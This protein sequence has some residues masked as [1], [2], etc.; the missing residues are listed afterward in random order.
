M[1]EPKPDEETAEILQL[2]ELAALVRTAILVARDRF[3]HP[4]KQKF[5]AFPKNCCGHASVLLV[6][7]LKDLG[8]KRVY[9]VFNGKHIQDVKKSHAWVEVGEIIVDITADQFP[10][11]PPVIVTDNR[12]WHA[13]FDGEQRTAEILEDF[14]EKAMQNYREAYAAVR[15]SLSIN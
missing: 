3:P 5:S 7:Y 12:K 14:S 10:D 15:E 13:C 6:L 1:A 9:R 2:R 8:V 11:N 4:L